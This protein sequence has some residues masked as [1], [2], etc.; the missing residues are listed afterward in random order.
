MDKTIF[1]ALI[2]DAPAKARDTVARTLSRYGEPALRF[3]AA[4]NVCVRILKPRE[5][6]ARA[7]ASLA[8]LGLDVDAWPA[9]PAGLFVVEERTVYLRSCS[10]MTIAHE[11]G[12]AL[13]CV[14][15]GGIYLSGIDPAI[16]ECF[17]NAHSFVTP[18]CAS[19][20]DEFMAECLRSYIGVNDEQSAWPQVNP[21]RLRS[22]D[23]VMFSICQQI[24]AKFNS[25]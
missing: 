10:P 16:R 6:Y 20:L 22:I 1:S 4:N 19:G 14:L 2:P 12:H 8:R 5:T 15:G 3:A 25:T 11:F 9:P 21:E 23:P 13:D 17:S 24:F 18:Y 7:S